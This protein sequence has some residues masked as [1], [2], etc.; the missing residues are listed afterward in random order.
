MAGQTRIDGHW[1]A[2]NREFVGERIGSPTYE[3]RLPVIVHMLTG[4]ETHDA[5]FRMAKQFTDKNNVV[6]KE[7][8]KAAD[9]CAAR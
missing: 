9:S 6:E 4:R 3:K 5:W 2:T 8:Q 1:V 7:I